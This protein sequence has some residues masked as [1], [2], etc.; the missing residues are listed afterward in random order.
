M[1]LERGHPRRTGGLEARAF[2]E[3]GRPAVREKDV[4]APVYFMD[5]PRP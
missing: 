2:T 1:R 5:N 3:N 4:A